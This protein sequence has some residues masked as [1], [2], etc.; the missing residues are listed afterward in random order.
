L[1]PNKEVF[2]SAALTVAAGGLTTSGSLLNQNKTGSV[3][4]TTNHFINREKE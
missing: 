1:L 4:D 3:I 2:G